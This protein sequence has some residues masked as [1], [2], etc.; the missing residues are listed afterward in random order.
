MPKVCAKKLS[1]SCIQFS[2]CCRVVDTS[3]APDGAAVRLVA[4]APGGLGVLAGLHA[5]L[6]GSDA[7]A[8]FQEL[9]ILPD[10][11]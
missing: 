1:K 9:R 7:G 5:A 3:V 4:H 10:E 11:R 8:R 6:S 2:L